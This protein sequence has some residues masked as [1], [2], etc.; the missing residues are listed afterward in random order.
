VAKA[1]TVTNQSNRTQKTLDS[2]KSKSMAGNTLQW[3]QVIVIAVNHVHMQK[4]R[5]KERIC[6]AP[7]TATGLL[8]WSREP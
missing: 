7:G 4:E 1:V 5:E 3:Q 8:Q 6:L 2:K